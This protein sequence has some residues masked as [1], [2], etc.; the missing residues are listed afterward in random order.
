MMHTKDI[1]EHRARALR[2]QELRALSRA[3]CSLALSA[4]SGRQTKRKDAFSSLDPVNDQTAK[5]DR[6]A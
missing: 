6:A 4:F 2:H 5:R 3:L 1:Y